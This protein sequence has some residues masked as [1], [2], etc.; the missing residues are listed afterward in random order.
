MKLERSSFG[1][2]HSNKWS[3]GKINMGNLKTWVLLSGAVAQWYGVWDVSFEPWVWSQAL[4][5]NK[6]QGTYIV[7]E[8]PSI[9]YWLSKSGKFKVEKPQGLPYPCL[10]RTQENLRFLHNKNRFSKTN[11]LLDMK[12]MDDQGTI[13]DSRNSG[14][15]TDNWS[16]NHT[17]VC[18]GRLGYLW[19]WTIFQPRP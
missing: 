8:Y 7:S 1:S 19:V 14:D 2:C 6:E 15:T 11:S 3:L 17:R 4:E 16:A 18:K 5:N 13:P 9:E 12:V 10:G